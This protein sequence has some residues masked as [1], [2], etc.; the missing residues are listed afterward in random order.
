MYKDAGRPVGLP[1]KPEIC[2]E[3]IM[4]NWGGELVTYLI[5]IWKVRM[6]SSVGIQSFHHPKAGIYVVG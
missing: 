5:G 6:I 4:M 3:F 1:V 2:G